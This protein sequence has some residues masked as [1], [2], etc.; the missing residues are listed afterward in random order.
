MKLTK[1][2][3]V[4]GKKQ[5]TWTRADTECTWKLES[6]CF[7]V[8]TSSI[9]VGRVDE[10]LD[11]CAGGGIG[12]IFYNWWKGN[13]FRLTNN[14]LIKL[15][16]ERDLDEMGDIFIQFGPTVRVKKIFIIN[17]I[18]IQYVLIITTTLAFQ[19]V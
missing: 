13:I 9:S 7:S 19:N 18:H 1:L 15:M 2:A 12:V 16:L 3:G 17:K 14:A 8:R 10:L 6:Y 11:G 5:H 4:R